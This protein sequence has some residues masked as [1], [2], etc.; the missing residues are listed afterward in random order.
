MGASVSL[1]AASPDQIARGRWWGGSNAGLCSSFGMSGSNGSEVLVLSALPRHARTPH[2]TT[3]LPT[4]NAQR[5]PALTGVRVQPANQAAGSWPCPSAIWPHWPVSVRPSSR[6]RRQP[7]TGDHVRVDDKGSVSATAN[8][9]GPRARQQG[10]AVT[11]NGGAVTEITAI[12]A[13]RP[14]LRQPWCAITT[15]CGTVYAYYYIL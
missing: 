1:Q 8:H 5:P 3:Q 13:R 12:N 10:A 11:H 15:C 4:P 9:K 6:N 2:T 7:A 14:V